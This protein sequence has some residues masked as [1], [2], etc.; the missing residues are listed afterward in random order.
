MKNIAN[1]LKLIIFLIYVTTIFFIKNYYILLAITIINLFSILIFKINIKKVIFNLISI[2]P[3]IIFTGLLN[4]IFANFNYGLLIFI[5]L[6]LVCNITY[7]FA[8]KFSYNKL[9]KAIEQILFFL[10]I[11]KINS[12][13]IG[14]IITISIAFLPILKQQLIDI[15]DGLKTKG[16][17]KIKYIIKVFLSSI[18]KR[19]DELSNTLKSKAYQEE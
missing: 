6:I 3:F 8:K 13:D 15:K 14:L 1:T 19:I 2:M 16:C 4:T 7:I 11:F 9:T 10:K 18:F 12:K 5:R 17:N